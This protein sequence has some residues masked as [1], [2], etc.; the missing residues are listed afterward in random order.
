MDTVNSPAEEPP[1]PFPLPPPLFTIAV[2]VVEARWVVV[3]VANVTALVV[4]AAVV[5]VGEVVEVR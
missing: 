5:A 4:V 2:L 3:D 1:P